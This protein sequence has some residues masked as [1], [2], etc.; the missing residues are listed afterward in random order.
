MKYCR[1]TLLAMGFALSASVCHVRANDGQVA[2]NECMQYIF[3]EEP[4]PLWQKFPQMPH[5]KQ[6]NYCIKFL[7]EKRP[8][9]L[10]GLD[11]GDFTQ[12]FSDGRFKHE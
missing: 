7:R 1:S 9:L 10:D 6:A 2:Y 12:G 3:V 11:L 4:T 8:D 5:K